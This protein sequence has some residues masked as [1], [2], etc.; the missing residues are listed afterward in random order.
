MSFRHRLA[1]L[2][3]VTLVAVQALTALFIYGYVRS[4]LVKKAEREL[5]AE[6]EQFTRQLDFLSERVTDGVQ[7]LSLDYA[8][9][10]AIARRDVETELSALR[11]HGHRIGTERMLL[12]GLQGEIAAD[13][14]QA[15]GPDGKFP[16]PKLLQAAASADKGTALAAIDGYIYWIVVVPVRAP[17]PIAFIAAFIPVDNGLLEK[18]RSIAS[19]PRSITLATKAM[20]GTWTIAAQSADR[21]GLLPPTSYADTG[22]A[23]SHATAADGR[24]YLSVVGRLQTLAE[25]AP[26]VAVVAY[27]LHEA[28]AVYRTIVTAMLVILILALLAALG[29]AMFIVR[30]VSRPLE[31][32]AAVAQRIASGDYTPP[33]VFRQR[34]EVG[35]LGNALR[36][37]TSAIAEREAAL[38]GA[39][40]SMEIALA[41]AVTANEAKSQF[42]TN[43]SHEFRT[44]LNAI[45]GFSGMLEQQVFG[46]LGQGRY[47]EYARDI[48]LSANH[49]LALVQRMLDLAEAAAGRLQIAHDS[50]APG[51]LLRESVILLKPF[52][53]K[54]G[55]RILLASEA[56]Q[57]PRMAGDAAKM[58]QAFI[59]LLHNAVKFSPAGAEV[60][61]SGAVKQE[62]LTVRICDR[63]AGI[64]PDLLPIIVRPFHRLRSSL[65]GRQQGA[66]VGL[67][68][69]KAIIEL[70]GGKLVLESTPNVGTTAII[71]LPLA[72]EPM[73]HAA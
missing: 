22:Q 55:V 72:A 70:H 14:R 28:L 57:W 30:G 46:P 67:P 64:E 15:G 6:L 63:G 40:E 53:E 65:D 12:I 56:T 73:R 11:N 25:S 26:V 52:S 8:L 29:G 58:R 71:E 24:E 42:L 20:D 47:V 2:L 51:V 7:V 31:G 36:E 3:V 16:F 10:A 60:T 41:Q 54:S 23:V 49:L 27:P 9:R 62:R 68:F 50:I 38:T 1:L 45:L 37:M 61:I 44:P 18:L 35:R 13:T 66:G 4:D 33:P 21:V 17:V 19:L 5:T 39:I 69:A 43:M 32:L 34:H 48:Q 59:N